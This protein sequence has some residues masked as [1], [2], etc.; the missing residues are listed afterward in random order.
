MAKN[1]L[2][3]VEDDLNQGLLYEEELEDDGYEVDVANSGAKALK[4]VKENTY[5]LVVLD[6]WM[7]GMDGLETLSRL[8]CI[9]NKIPVIINTA[10]SSY[11]DD[12][13]SWVAEAYVVK[14]SNITELKEKI[15]ESV[16]RKM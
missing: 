10:Y 5:D 11:K 15:K 2:L 7:P 12:F 1:R 13:M 9:D 6:I 16:S 14:S 3:V 4:M 8:L